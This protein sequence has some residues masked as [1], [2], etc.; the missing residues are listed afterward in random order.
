MTKT[1]F[2]ITLAAAGALA[3]CGTAR[4]TVVNI[5]A[6]TD[7]TSVGSSVDNPNLSVGATAVFHDAVTLTLAAGDYVISDGAGLPGA[8]YD[9]WNFETS[10]GGSWT[11]HFWI[12]A[13]QSGPSSGADYTILIDGQ[14]GGGPG[15]FGGF[16]TEADASAAFEASAPISLHLAQET[17]IGFT[18]T[19]YDLQDN[20]GGIS[21]SVVAAASPVPEPAS[22]ASILAGLVALGAVALRRRARGVSPRV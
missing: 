9:A 16:N 17:T 18:S 2:L 22:M 15:H 5:Q 21:L 13:Y 8:E 1:T 14:D 3:L 6:Y 7:G 19:D 10:V 12:G 4:A 20:L 11:N